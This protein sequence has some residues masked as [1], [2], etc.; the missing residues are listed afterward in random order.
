MRSLSGLWTHPCSRPRIR[1]CCRTAWYG[2]RAMQTVRA[3]P[4]IRTRPRT[5]THT[6]IFKEAEDPQSASSGGASRIQEGRY[7]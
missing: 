7:L 3:R 1:L 4:R 5:S 6:L 2:D